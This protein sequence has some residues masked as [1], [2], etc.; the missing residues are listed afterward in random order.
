MQDIPH[1]KRSFMNLIKNIG[2]LDVAQI[3][4]V[5]YYSVTVGIPFVKTK[6]NRKID[7]QLGTNYA[8]LCSYVP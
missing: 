3:L 1:G 4:C 6:M 2:V 7:G 8:S 5:L